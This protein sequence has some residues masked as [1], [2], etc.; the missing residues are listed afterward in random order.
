MPSSIQ[1]LS[2]RG[3]AWLLAM[4]L[5]LGGAAQTQAQAQT[6]A[7]VQ[8]LGDGL[9]YL[10][11]EAGVALQPPSL[12]APAD[13]GSGLPSLPYL[14]SL[15]L[16]NDSELARQRYEMRATKQEVP[17]AWAG[18]KPQVSASAAYS[19]QQADNIYTDNPERYP[20]EVYDDRVS[21]ATNDTYWQIQLTQPLFN[22]ERWREVE[23]AEEQVDAAML[24]VAVAERDLALMV[25]EA[26][27]N[28][29]LASRKL[30]LL[31]SKREALELQLRQAQRSFDLG[32]GDRINVME[33]QARLDQAVADQVQAENQL[34]NAL[35]DLQRLTGRLPDFTGFSLGN[36]E[37]IE[38]EPQRVEPEVW[39]SRA[40]NNVQVRLAEQRYEVAQAATEVRRASRYPEL[41]LNLSYGD[42]DSSDELRSSED[43][44]ASVELSAPIYRGG[45]TSASIRQGELTALAGR[46]AMVNELRLA[47]VEVRQRLRSLEGDL[48]QLEALS[49]SID[50]S[51]LFLEAAIKGEALGLRDLVDVLDARAELYDLRIQFVEVLCRYI[52]DRLNLEAAVGGL[53]TTDLIEAMDLLQRIT[54]NEA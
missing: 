14:L 48:R 10:N 38:L 27:L 36:L 6:P 52:N 21:G 12:D 15:A 4:A 9:P 46:A 20:D 17:M 23:R 41:N 49:R 28:A 19:F 33:S 16:K 13:A 39:L 2:G 35:S 29:Y 1:T 22:L 40:S 51:A 53:D 43:Y 26:Y 7:Q 31:D 25:V 32:L 18:L 42:R 34:A 47:R 11:G 50:S 3:S 37:T 45:F 30:G 44:T 54:L 5:L 24:T 8:A